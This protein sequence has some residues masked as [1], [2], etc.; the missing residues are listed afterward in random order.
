MVKPGEQILSPQKCRFCWPG[1]YDRRIKSTLG[2]WD[3]IFTKP[4]L[5][6][7]I[8]TQEMVRYLKEIPF[9]DLHVIMPHIDC[10]PL[11]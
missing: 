1:N 9:H 11:S 10:A 5:E 4:R 7:M 6:S 3:T 2:K 8:F